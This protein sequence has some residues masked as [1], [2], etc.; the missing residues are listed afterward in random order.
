MKNSRSL[1]L[2]RPG[3]ILGLA[4]GFVL[5]AGTAILFAVST[6]ERHR[7]GQYPHTQYTGNPS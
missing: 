6:R 4:A 7:L 3:V 5:T 1:L 2:S